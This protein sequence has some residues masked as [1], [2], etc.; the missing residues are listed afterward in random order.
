MLKKLFEK[1]FGIVEIK[2][3]YAPTRLSAWTVRAGFENIRDILK[4]DGPK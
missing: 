3:P 2:E 1:Y 4:Q